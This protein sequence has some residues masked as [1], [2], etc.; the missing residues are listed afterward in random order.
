MHSNI[1]DIATARRRRAEACAAHAKRTDRGSIE[2]SPEQLPQFAAPRVMHQLALMLDDESV[3]LAFVPRAT[4]IERLRFAHS[5]D[6]FVQLV[7]VT[8][9]R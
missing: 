7:R 9:D 8:L 5:C 6:E 4:M 1:T 2:I 3:E